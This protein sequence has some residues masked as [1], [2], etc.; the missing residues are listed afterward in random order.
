[1]TEV[2]PARRAAAIL[3]DVIS[4]VVPAHDERAV[5]G[6]LLTALGADRGGLEVIVVCNGCSDDTAEVAR[7]FPGV[8]VICTPVPSKAEALRLGDAAAGHFPRVYVDADVEIDRAGV[9]ALARTLERPGVLVTAPERRVPRTRVSLPVRWWYDVWE[10]LP[11]VRRGAFGRGVVA[12]SRAGHQRVAG[13]PRLMA[14][15]LAMSAAFADPER[16][17][18]TEAVVV[19]HPPRT[20]ADLIR[21]RVRTSTGTA[22]AYASDTG[23]RTDSRTATADLLALGRRRPVLAPKIAVFAAVA[24]IAR[25]RAA[26]AVAAG[27]YSTW[28]RDG[29]SRQVD[30]PG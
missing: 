24:V 11:T 18:T 4:V 10:Q 23:W 8:R 26:A 9:L 7:S 6:R 5:I 2:P 1:V 13:L 19:V 14:D 28:L 30:P 22:Q 29:S 21:R 20:W 15:D 12:L 16:C 27:D 25:R 17:I 3:L